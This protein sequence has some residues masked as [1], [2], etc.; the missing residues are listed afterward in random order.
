MLRVLRVVS[1]LCLERG[2]FGIA[3]HQPRLILVPLLLRRTVAALTIH[4]VE[5]VGR[6]LRLAHRAGGNQ[7][8]RCTQ[9]V[10]R[11]E[12]LLRETELASRRLAG[13]WMQEPV[14]MPFD[15]AELRHRVAREG[16]LDPAR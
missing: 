1:K 15:A 8:F 16:F 4:E 11:Y 12:C 3:I 7:C 10:A 5:E 9:L 2:S 6:Q 14:A 13:R